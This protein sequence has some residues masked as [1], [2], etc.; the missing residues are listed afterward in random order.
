MAITVSSVGEANGVP[1]TVEI[2][3][4]VSVLAGTVAEAT[5]TAAESGQAVVDA[6]TVGGIAEADVSTTEYT[7]QPEYD[8]SGN[9]QRLLGYRVG[10][11]MRAKVRDVGRAGEIVDSVSAAGG[12]HS[13]VRGLRFG[14]E[15][16]AALEASA[17]EAAWNVAVTKATQLAMLSG[18]TLG[19]ATS[20]TETVRSPVVPMRMM[21]ADVGMAEGAT[22]PIQPGTTTVTVDLRVEFAVSE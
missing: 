4:G 19:R 21:A 18:Q 16:D 15:D 22:T 7:V 14:V 6:L 12:D 10:N 9:Q 8:Y 1:D 5:K 2:D 13:R 11:T 20:I 17:R 3:V